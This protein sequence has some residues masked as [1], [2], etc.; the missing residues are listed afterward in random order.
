MGFSLMSGIALLQ[1]QN[2]KRLRQKKRL[3]HIEA[4]F[5]LITALVMIGIP[6]FATKKKSY[7][8]KKGI[9]YC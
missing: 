4:L 2:L 6:T 1:R 8:S 9:I 7:S 3:V 5:C